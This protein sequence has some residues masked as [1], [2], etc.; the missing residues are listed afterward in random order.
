M[1][2]VIQ[3]SFAKGEVSP[4]LF[5]RVDLRTYQIALKTARNCIVH[6]FGGISN[7][8]GLKFIGPVKDHSK[9]PRLIPFQF[10]TTDTHIIEMGDGYMR[11]LRNDSHITET[12]LSITGATQANPVKITTSASHGLVNDDEV[13]ISGVGGMTEINNQRF[14]VT[15][16]DA[17]EFTLK[18]QVTGNGINGTAFTA[19]TSGGTF[20]RIYTIA[21][22]YTQD[23]LRDIKFTQ[24]ADVMILTHPS[25]PPKELKRFALA[26]WTLTDIVFRPT[27]D[28]P[29]GLTTS[30]GTGGIDAYY[31][32]TAIADN[33]EESLAG[34]NATAKTITGVT[35]A[36]PAVVTSTAHG[37][38]NGDIVHIDGIVGMT[39]LNDRRFTVANQTANTFELLGENSTNYTT[40]VSGGTANQTF[41][42]NTNDTNVTISWTA[43]T[44]AVRY[45]VFKKSQGVFGFLASTDAN[46]FVDPGTIVPDI[47]DTPPRLIEPFLGTDNYPSAVGFHQQRLLMGGS[48]NKPD[49]TYYSVVGNFNNFSASVPIRAN[50]G[51]SVSLNSGEVNQIR[52]YISV[53]SLIIFT[54]GAEWAVKGSSG[55]SRFSIDTIEQNEQTNSGTGQLPP[56][57]INQ[58]I[59]YTPPGQN[60]VYSFQFTFE[61]DHYTVKN[62]SILSDHLFKY[63]RIVEWGQVKVGEPLI[64]SVRD[65]GKILVLTFNEEQEVSAWA[66]WDTNGNFESVATIF[67]TANCVCDPY[68]QPFFVVKRR[69]NGN[70]VRYIE[71]AVSRLF[72]DVQDCFFVDSGLSLDNPITITGITSAN[73]VVVTAPSHGFVNGDTVDITDIV[74]TQTLD[75]FGNIVT[76]AFTVNNGRFFVANATGNTFSLQS[77][78]DM[79]N[80]D[81]TAMPAYLE[82]GKVRKAVTT[83]SGLFH[84]KN[85]PVSVLADGN[86]ISN[87][88][89][90]N[91]GSITLPRKFSRVHVGLQYISDIETL[92]PEPDSA[93]FRTLQAKPVKISEVTVRFY[94][95]RG[96]L[97]GPDN[98]R[99]TEMKQREFEVLGEPTALLT[100]DKKIAISSHWNSEGRVFIR[101]ISPLPLTVL[102]IMA[103][104]EYGEL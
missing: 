31:T 80:I 67:P 23:Q 27:I 94:R 52:H 40:Y 100:G 87:I 64:Y 36:N 3:P 90:S 43:I 97:I 29:T 39:Q 6:Q 89:V 63:N 9:A 25:H 71:R 55:D 81:G 11:F 15:V 41:V 101:Q 99:L 10:K 61:D 82:N 8:P 86:V 57:D 16:V 20:A 95:S 77:L 88:T 4:E 44:N 74:L 102:A 91:T 18:D 38:S 47:G 22:P 32:V 21:T 78:E 54:S 58:T 28:F 46:S 49:T 48:N 19:Y 60:A 76:P 5:G 96:L 14:R 98:T 85:T 72:K 45:R 69:I 68:D 2:E 17:D 35:K 93:R 24:T 1:A 104:A 7:R 66:T 33:G 12:A 34:I 103:D 59:L 37:F 84:L 13:F 26:N 83:V 73:P 70:I 79:S 65:D 62:M 56:L 51:F 50:D 30:G 42:F 92:K 53:N 75:S